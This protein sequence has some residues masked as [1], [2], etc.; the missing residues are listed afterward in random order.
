MENIKSDVMQEQK[1]NLDTVDSYGNEL[2]EKIIQALENEV[3]KFN[4]GRGF[5]DNFLDRFF[6][7]IEGEE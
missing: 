5:N 4:S 7:D 1:N 3:H 2:E 6:I